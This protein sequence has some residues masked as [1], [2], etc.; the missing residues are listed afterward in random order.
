MPSISAA[1]E[2]P[3]AAP[4][5]ADELRLLIEKARS[6]P[7]VHGVPGLE[8][9]M[10]YRLAAETGLRA[11]EIK[12]LQRQSFDLDGSPPTVT[13]HA[14]YSKHRRE[15][16]LPLRPDTAAVLRQFLAGRLPEAPAFR[17]PGWLQMS[18][19]VRVDRGGSRHPLS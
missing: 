7:T 14:G 13:V 2:P 10:I 12:S 16:V 6:G 19:L 5:T 18:T 17:V 4:L 9:A 3:A 11:G 8:R 1:G 15:D